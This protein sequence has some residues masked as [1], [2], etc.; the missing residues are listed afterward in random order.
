MVAKERGGFPVVTRNLVG[1]SPVVALAIPS[2]GSTGG[3][4]DPGISDREQE[5]RRITV[6]R[7]RPLNLSILRRNREAYLTDESLSPRER[8]LRAA[9]HDRTLADLS[10]YFRFL[11]HTD[12]RRHFDNPPQSIEDLRQRWDTRVHYPFAVN[13][14]GQ[15][16]GGLTIVDAEI[17]QHD[18]WITKVVIDPKLQRR[19]GV[20]TQVMYHGIEWAFSN[21]TSDGVQRSK[22]DTSV[23]MFIPGWERMFHLIEK[24][25]F[26]FRMMLPRQVTVQRSRGPSEEKPTMRWELQQWKWNRYKKGI[27]ESIRDHLNSLR[28]PPPQR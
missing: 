8:T 14:L 15:V 26:E 23:I 24:L 1:D 12:N 7:V 13:R 2:G 6:A 19:Q 18:H 20:G 17:A 21:R 16:V 9:E 3:D 11:S 25:G 10:T 22:L 4:H 27:H 28:N 5:A